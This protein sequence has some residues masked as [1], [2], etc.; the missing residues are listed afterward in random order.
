M[1]RLHGLQVL[2]N[3]NEPVPEEMS[4]K[5]PAEFV[6]PV[7]H[8]AAKHALRFAL[9]VALTLPLKVNVM[10]IVSDCVK[11]SVVTV[12]KA[13]V[14]SVT[15]PVVANVAKVN[16]E[17]TLCCTSS[18]PVFICKQTLKVSSRL[19]LPEARL[20][21]IACEKVGFDALPVMEEPVLVKSTVEQ[22]AKTNCTFSPAAFAVPV[23]VKVGVVLTT[24]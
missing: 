16:A 18:E 17:L 19:P 5:V 10:T 23:S 14:T 13:G 8:V 1:Q 2:L 20:A 11:L 7:L 3:V 24:A 12:D 15:S 9:G 6:Q 21:V 4:T 22:A